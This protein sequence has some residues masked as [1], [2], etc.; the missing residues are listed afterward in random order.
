MGPVIGQHTEE[1]LKELKYSSTEIR[2]F[3]D[4]SIVYQLPNSKL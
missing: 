4:Q 2:N 3:L 1:I